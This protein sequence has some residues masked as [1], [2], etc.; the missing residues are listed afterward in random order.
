MKKHWKLRAAKT[1]AMMDMVCDNLNCVG[2]NHPSQ[3]KLN[4]ELGIHKL[5]HGKKNKNA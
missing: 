5:N 2:L 1:I 3:T 4:Q